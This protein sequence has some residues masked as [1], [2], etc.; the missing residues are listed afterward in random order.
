MAITINQMVVFYVRPTFCKTHG[1]K[2]LL[3]NVINETDKIC[4]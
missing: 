4:N 1:H 2:I 3:T